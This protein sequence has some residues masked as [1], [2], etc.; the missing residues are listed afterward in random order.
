MAIGC[1]IAHAK[2][3][4]YADGP[5]PERAKAGIGLWCRLCDRPDRRGRA[6]R[7]WSTGCRWT[8]SATVVHFSSVLIVS[9]ILLAPIEDWTLLVMLVL[10]CGLIG[11]AYLGPSVAMP[12]ATA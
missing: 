11:V 7:R 2:A 1:G 3:V 10:A 8:L 6:F 9:L 12:R 4:A 5:E